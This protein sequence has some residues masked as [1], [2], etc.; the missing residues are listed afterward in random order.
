MYT[1]ILNIF[2][3]I[4]AN[5][6]A[7]R[8]WKIG[9]EAPGTHLTNIKLNHDNYSLVIPESGRYFLYSQVGFLVYYNG[10]DTGVHPEEGAQSL[11]HFVYRYNV[12]YPSP[13]EKLLRSDITQCWEK[14]KDYGRY[15]SY[16]GASV[17]LNKGDQIYVKVSKIELLSK[18]ESGLTYF[19]LFKMG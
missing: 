12:I 13:H 2:I 3:L 11:F 16:V 6:Q 15:T 9:R 7:I 17:Q 1:C 10:E 14:R 18:G 8:N 4:S 19:G 5:E